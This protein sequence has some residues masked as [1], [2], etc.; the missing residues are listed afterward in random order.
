MAGATDVASERCRSWAVI[1]DPNRVQEGQKLSF[2]SLI[3]I[4]LNQAH[5][6]DLRLSVPFATWVCARTLP[7]LLLFVT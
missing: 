5:W 3:E 2:V 6:N 1:L 7:K 4:Q